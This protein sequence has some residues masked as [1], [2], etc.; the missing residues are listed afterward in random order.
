MPTELLDCLEPMLVQHLADTKRTNMYVANYN[1]MTN[2]FKAGF[3]MTKK[4]LFQAIRGHYDFINAQVIV[5]ALGEDEFSGNPDGHWIVVAVDFS[6]DTVY[7][8]DSYNRQNGARTIFERVKNLFIAPHLSYLPEDDGP[9]DIPQ[10]GKVSMDSVCINEHK[11][12]GSKQSRCQQHRT[13][14]TAVDSG[15]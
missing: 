11:L 5:F 8:Y 10:T 1:V 4:D 6:C 9:L 15:Q 7:K 2:A 13:M 14:S 3:V 12:L